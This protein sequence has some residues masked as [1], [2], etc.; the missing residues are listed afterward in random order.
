M[1]NL[2]PPLRGRDWVYIV[3]QV[4][5]RFAGNLA[6]IISTKART[7]LSLA[8]V[9]EDLISSRGRRSAR[10][11]MPIMRSCM[12]AYRHATGE[13][14]A[15]CVTRPNS[16]SEGDNSE[17]CTNAVYFAYNYLDNKDNRP[18]K[19]CDW[20]Y[21]EWIERAFFRSPLNDIFVG[22]FLIIFFSYKNAKVNYLVAHPYPQYACMP[23]FTHCVAKRRRIS[24]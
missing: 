1:V 16:G 8:H 20:V 10:D 7:D 23:M 22:I 14:R 15:C 11:Q 12:L 19:T 6:L 24:F 2:S 13:E 9:P 5:E 17:C 4:G 3:R 21:F 18:Q